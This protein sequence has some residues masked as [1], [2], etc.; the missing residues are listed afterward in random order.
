MSISFARVSEVRHMQDNMTADGLFFGKTDVI[1]A[2]RIVPGK[3][4]QHFLFIMKTIHPVSRKVV[5]FVDKCL[6]FGS[7]IR[8][9]IFQAFSDALAH[10]MEYKV[11]FVIVITNYL[12]DF[13]FIAYTLKMCRDMVLKFIKLC[14]W[15]GF[16]TSEEK[17]EWGT[18][19]TT[20]LGMLLKGKRYLVSI[21]VEKQ[22]KA[23]DLINKVV[24]KR[25]VM[26][27]FIQKLTGLLN[28]INR[29][30]VPGAYIH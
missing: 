1:S 11:N 9:A 18:Q 12:D 22:N 19:I 28:F 8:C 6:Q 27:R 5:F 24:D 25:T 3:P 20:F 17:T 29:A 13:L 15:L 26:I 21:P 4:S 14:T 23:L 2:F 16:P 30:V 7:S 10:I